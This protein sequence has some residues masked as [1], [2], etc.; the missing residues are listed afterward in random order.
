M[1]NPVVAAPEHKMYFEAGYYPTNRF[2]ITAGV[3][4]IEGLYTS[5]SYENEKKENF[6][7]VNARTSYQINSF[8]N[9]FIKGDNLLRQRY[10]INAGYPMPMATVSGGFNINI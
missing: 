10:E 1:K 3:Q 7:L 6:T 9:I 4:H 5:V 2:C 8:M